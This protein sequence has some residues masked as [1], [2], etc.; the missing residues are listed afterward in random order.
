MCTSLTPTHSLN[1]QVSAACTS[2]L[3]VENT[4]STE[5]GRSINPQPK[6]K[7]IFLINLAKGNFYKKFCQDVAK[8]SIIFFRYC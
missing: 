6:F 8:I 1:P 2:D 5:N 3:K 7:V 4:R